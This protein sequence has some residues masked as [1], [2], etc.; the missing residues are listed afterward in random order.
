MAGG[1]K[2]VKG[3][4][5]PMA[6]AVAVG[7]AGLIGGAAVGAAEAEERG[8]GDQG[9]GGTGGAEGAGLGQVLWRM[10]SA[11]APRA[12]SRVGKKASG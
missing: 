1:V 11:G 8:R 10:G 6:G 5:I 4:V 12:I 3:I 7:V 2:D 9:G